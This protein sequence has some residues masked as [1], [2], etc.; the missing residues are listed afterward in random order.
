MQVFKIKPSRFNSGF[1]LYEMTFNS[2]V[3]R[4]VIVCSIRL[5]KNVTQVTTKDCDN[6]KS[7]LT[8]KLTPK[9]QKQ[10]KFDTS[11]L[12]QGLAEIVA[13]WPEL[14]EHIKAAIKALVQ[15]HKTEKK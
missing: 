6:S 7:A 9:F 8:P 11:E 5:P 13:V 2:F 1:P 4:A 3:L 15:T 10:P 12:S 14:S